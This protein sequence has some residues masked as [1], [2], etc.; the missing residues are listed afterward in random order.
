MSSKLFVGNLSFSTTEDQLQ[1]AFGQFGN[2]VEAKIIL[3]RDTG[4]P[5]GFGFVTM[6][7]ENSAQEAIDGMNGTMLD[8][9]PLRV[10]IA[11]ERRPP[12]GGGGGGGGG[13]Y[14][15]PRGGGGRGRPR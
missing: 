9:R 4:R 8:G 3:D 14:G 10:N 7:S 13:G 6:D 12:R 2:V 5:R 11:E 15:G 1:E